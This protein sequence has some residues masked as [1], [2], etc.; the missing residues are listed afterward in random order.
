MKKKGKK[1]SLFLSLIIIIAV[2][3][4]IGLIGWLGYEGY[5]KYETEKTAEDI[6]N[7]F[8]NNV[9]EKLTE[10]KLQKENEE[11]KAIGG[12][13][14]KTRRR[15]KKT[16]YTTRYDDCIVIGTIRIPDINIKYPIMNKQTEEAMKIGVVFVFGPG[17]TGELGESGEP[18]LNEVGNAVILGHN[19]R[20]GTL[21]AKIGKLKKGASI[22]IKDANGREI[23]YKVYKVSAASP[24]DNSFYNQNTNGKREITLS[25]C[26]KD[27]SARTIVQALEK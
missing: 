7:T 13:N 18:Q 27:G 5:E 26:N 11:E 17:I 8:E 10:E 9:E 3:G 6:V 12:E 15:S 16:D 23:E 1:F 19:Y 24:V 2:C 22:F 21:F 14:T 20:N 4:I 25:T